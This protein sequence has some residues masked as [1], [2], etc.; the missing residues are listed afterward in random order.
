MKKKFLV[1]LTA[2]IMVFNLMTSIGAATNINVGDYVQ[3]DEK[4]I[5]ENKFITE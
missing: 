1:L 2:L 5:A 3:C 4:I